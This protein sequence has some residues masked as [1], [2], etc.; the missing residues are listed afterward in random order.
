MPESLGPKIAAL[1]QQRV[2]YPEIEIILDCARSTIAYHAKRLNLA[3]TLYYYDWAALKER[4]DAGATIAE[5][6]SIF[7]MSRSAIYRAADRGD[8][9]LRERH[10]RST[11]EKAKQQKDWYRQNRDAHLAKTI[12]NARKQKKRVFAHYGESCVCC[13]EAHPDFLAMD[14]INNDGASHRKDINGNNR[15]GRIYGWLIRNNFPQA[16]QTLCHNCN[17]SKHLNKGQCIHQIEKELAAR[18]RV[19]LRSEL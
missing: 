14:H 13:G 1:L 11:E 9:A 4:Y 15:S 2:S 6:S 5:L 10:F 12:D 17:F 8:L 3:P 19:E 16:F 7:G 18:R